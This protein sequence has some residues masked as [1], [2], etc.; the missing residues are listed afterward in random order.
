MN[1]IEKIYRRSDDVEKFAKEYLHYKE[2]MDL[3]KMF[4]WC[5]II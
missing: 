2:S 5:S 1:N 3:L 4:A